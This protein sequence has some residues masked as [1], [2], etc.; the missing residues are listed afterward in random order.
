[1]NRTFSLACGTL[2]VAGSLTVAAQTP[3]T[4]QTPTTQP[5]TPSRTDANRPDDKTMT[6]TGCL[7]TWDAA[8]GAA[9]TGTSAGTSAAGT[10]GGGRFV[11]TNVEDGASGANAGAAAPPASATGTGNTAGTSAM[12][13]GKQYTIVADSGVNLAPHVNHQV[14]IT[15]RLS[16]GDQMMSGAKPGGTTSDPSRPPEASR[17]ADSGRSAAGMT[18]L[19]ATAVTMIS[20]TCS[21]ATK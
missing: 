21:G 12:G 14:R 3:A 1:M 13:A 20:N 2:A 17:P 7:K 19:S 16:Q 10:S 9:S 5:S 6:V 18:T 11:L 15:G 4:P 8:M